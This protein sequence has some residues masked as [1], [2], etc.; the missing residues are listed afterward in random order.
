[1]LTVPVLVALISVVTL[2]AVLL[3]NSEA[4][5]LGF[6]KSIIDEVSKNTQELS[7]KA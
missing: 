7:A 3:K 2:V 5:V 6:E 4:G 1:M